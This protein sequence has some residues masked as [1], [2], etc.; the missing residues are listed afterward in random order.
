MKILIVEDDPY[1]SDM[2]K[3]GLEESGFTVELCDDG[4]E[5]EYIALNNSFDV[6]I[7]DWMLPNKDGISILKSLRENSI[8]TPI[9]MLTAKDEIAD[10]VKGLTNGADDYLAKPFS[11]DELIARLEAL[12]R[13][14]LG[15]A[16]NFLE[17]G[18]LKIDLSNRELRKDG[19][20]IALTQKEYE[21]LLFLIKHKNQIVSSSFIQNELWRDYEYINSNVI[22]VTIYHLRKKIGK[23]YISSER[24]LG[25]KFRQPTEP[26]NDKFN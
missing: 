2:L 3:R 16:N 13:R 1:I 12:Y 24:K 11:F 6:I 9:L 4:E 10:K 7:L 20:K 17:I 18:S 8:N 14:S 19:V 26:A 21:L 15:G 22:Q 23:E 25:Y 5:G